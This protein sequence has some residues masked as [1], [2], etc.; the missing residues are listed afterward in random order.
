MIVG[1]SVSYSALLECLVHFRGILLN[2]ESRPETASEVGALRRSIL[3]VPPITLT[4]LSSDGCDLGPAVANRREEAFNIITQ[5]SDFR[6]HRLWRGGTLVFEGGHRKGALAITDL[7]EEWR[8]HH[9]SPFDNVRLQ[10]PFSQMRAFA[11]EQG[12][13]DFTGLRC[14]PGTH[15]GVMLGL[16]QALLPAFERPQEASQLFLDQVSLAILTHLMQTY[17]GLYLPKERKGTLAAWQEK[18][19]LD[20]L[21]GHVDGQFSL[22]ELAEA[23]ALSKSYFIKAFKVSFGCTPLRWLAEYRVTRAKELLLKNVP[24]AEIAISCGFADQS[25]MT[26]TFVAIAGETPARFRRT[27]RLELEKAPL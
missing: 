2:L 5:L 18:R 7:R 25:H 17:G 16:A 9:L 20:F 6:L 19:A 14:A 23:C 15:D 26:K 8:C 22:S 4:R 24:I 10:I 12:R 27:R 3:R 11:T 13:P 1:G 21:S